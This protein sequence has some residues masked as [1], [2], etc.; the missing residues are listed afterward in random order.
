[1]PGPKVVLITGVSSGIG[2]AAAIGFA[3]AGCRVYGT[4]RD[5]AKVERI[6]GVTLIEMDIRPL[7]S[8]AR[9]V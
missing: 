9:A 7:R 5:T 1:M 2:R 6:D 3:R 8:L 4:V